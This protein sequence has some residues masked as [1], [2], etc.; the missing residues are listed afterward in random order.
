MPLENTMRVYYFDKTNTVID[1]A[2]FA[3]N[4]T[5]EE[6][7]EFLS[8]RKNLNSNII[9]YLTS[10][11]CGHDGI[12]ATLIDGRLRPPCNF[13]SWAWNNE[14]EQW[15]PPVPCPEPFYDYWWNEST[16][17]WIKELP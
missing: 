14:S 5:S 2:V 17:E 12:G 1:V 7:N 16:V 3:D 15:E 13:P 10:K 9:S 8:V 6:L 4:T 11:E